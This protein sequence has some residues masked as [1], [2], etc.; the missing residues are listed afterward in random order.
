M[1]SARSALTFATVAI[2]TAAALTACGNE[3]KN[4]AGTDCQTAAIR[5][6]AAAEIIVLGMG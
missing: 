4:F 6:P 5:M 3:S 1:T 2:L